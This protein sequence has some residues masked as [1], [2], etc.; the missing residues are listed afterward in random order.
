M[1]LCELMSGLREVIDNNDSKPSYEGLVKPVLD[2]LNKDANLLYQ[3][4]NRDVNEI[5]KLDI[6]T[7]YTEVNLCKKIKE[8]NP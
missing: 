8:F 7:F 2:T 6:K 5:K 3:I 4:T 1:E